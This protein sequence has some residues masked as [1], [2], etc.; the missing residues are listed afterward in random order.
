MAKYI[1]FN[2]HSYLIHICCKKEQEDLR[3]SFDHA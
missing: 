3:S 1:D 2:T